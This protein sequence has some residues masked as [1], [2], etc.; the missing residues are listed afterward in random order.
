MKVSEVQSIFVENQQN[1]AFLFGNG[2][3]RHFNKEIHSWEGLL[4]ELW[5]K[6]SNH[7]AKPSIPSGISMTEFYDV[8]QLKLGREENIDNEI[9]KTVKS[10]IQQWDGDHAQNVIVD[11]IRSMEA[12]LLTTNFDQ[13]M[14]DTLDLSL[15]KLPV[16]R[17]TDFYPWAC[18]FSNEVLQNPLDG[19]GIWH[20]NGMANYHRSIKLGLSHYMS[21]VSRAKEFLQGDLYKHDINDHRGSNFINSWLNIIFHKSLFIVGLSLD[22]N[23]VF[24]RWLL[25]ERAKYFHRYF[26]R[27]QKGWYILKKGE[28]SISDGKKFFLES[29]GFEII[30]LDDYESIYEKIWEF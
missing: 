7:I 4:L 26:D 3:N 14:A 28:N 16:S 1:I 11:K 29:V 13:L 12:P 6:F 24:L 20:I 10:I 21:N 19:F 27:K 5:E 8:F 23:E 15:N 22:E 17:F 30:E 18:Y 9:Q 2:I 25:I